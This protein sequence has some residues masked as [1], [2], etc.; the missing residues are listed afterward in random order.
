MDTQAHRQAIVD[1]L[2]GAGKAPPP[3]VALDGFLTTVTPVLVG[4]LKVPPREFERTPCRHPC[5]TE[6]SSGRSYPNRPKPLN[7]FGPHSCSLHLI[8]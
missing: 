2:S 5:G 1:K 3:L 4:I 8:D 6:N 7:C